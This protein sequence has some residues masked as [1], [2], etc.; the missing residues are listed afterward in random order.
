MK[1]IPLT[2]GKYA[3]IDDEDFEYVKKFK[4]HASRQRGHNRFYVARAGTKTD[5]TR[6]GRLVWMHREINKTPEGLFT[7]HI[8]GNGLDNRRSNLRTVTTAENMSNIHYMSRNTSGVI[9]VHFNKM[10]RKWVPRVMRNGNRMTLG[11]FEDLEEA[12]AA[13]WAYTE[14]AK[15]NP[16]GLSL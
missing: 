8:N 3:L 13:R 5:G 1:K 14:I 4:W 11:E 9:G 7:D 10:K 15:L 2:Q 12:A 16:Q 6:N